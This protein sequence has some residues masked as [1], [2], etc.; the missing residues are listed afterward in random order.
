MQGPKQI[1]IRRKKVKENDMSCIFVKTSKLDIPEWVPST[2]SPRPIHFTNSWFSSNYIKNPVQTNIEKYDIKAPT[3]PQ[4]SYNQQKALIRRIKSKRVPEFISTEKVKLYVTSEQHIILQEWMNAFIKM[5][6]VTVDYINKKIFIDKKVDI[7]IAKQTCSFYSLRSQLIRHKKKINKPL[8]N[9]MYIHLFDEAIKHAVTSFKSCISNFQ[10]GHIRKFRVRE[11]SYDK[12]RKILIIESSFFK[13][14]QLFPE[15]LGQ[16]ASSSSLYHVNKTTT[17]HYNLHTGNYLLLVPITTKQKTY[18]AKKIDCGCDGGGRTFMTTYS[19]NESY[20]MGTNMNEVLKPIHKKINKIGK[21]MKTDG[22]S[23]DKKHKLKRS[24]RKHRERLKNIVKD[25]HYKV[26]R[27]LVTTY[28]NIYLGKLSTSRII[29]RSNNL[30][31][32]AKEVIKSLSHYTF[33]MILTHMGHKYGATVYLVNEYL[34]TMTCSGCGNIK[35]VQDARTYKCNKCGLKT[36]RDENAGKNIL[37]VGY[38][39]ADLLT[40]VK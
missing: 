27:F 38:K 24:L 13:N 2:R 15:I 10:N 1:A 23:R 19:V 34:T 16:I 28:D 30:P 35:K 22:I 20:S 5:Y 9:K 17:L 25:M 14:G 4:A 3:I 36:G 11:M 26:A 18:E 6:N 31:K 40:K 37:K 39:K 7:N 33:R 29:S 32:S 12:P 21:A 8:T